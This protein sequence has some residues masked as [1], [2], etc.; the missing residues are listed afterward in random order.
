MHKEI[1]KS[2]LNPAVNKLYDE[3]LGDIGGEKAHKLLHTSYQKR[4]FK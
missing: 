1:R 4:E 2:H 3:Y